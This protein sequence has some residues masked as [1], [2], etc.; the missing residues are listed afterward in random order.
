MLFQEHARFF[1]FHFTSKLK[2]RTNMVIR[3]QEMDIPKPNLYNEGESST[4]DP[5]SNDERRADSFV[6]TLFDRRCYSRRRRT[7]TKLAPISVHS[8]RAALFYMRSQDNAMHT[9]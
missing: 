3:Q 7:L 9:V 5:K 1:S 4:G 8:N 2:L 6:F